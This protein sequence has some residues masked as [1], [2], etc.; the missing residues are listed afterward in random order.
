M[1]SGRIEI[2]M[3][4]LLFALAFLV[5][6]GSIFL[7]VRSSATTVI[8]DAHGHCSERHGNVLIEYF[9]YVRS[10]QRSAVRRGG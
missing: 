4:F 9:Y 1:V 2:F 8:P 7:F 3:K 5:V 10:N 6:F